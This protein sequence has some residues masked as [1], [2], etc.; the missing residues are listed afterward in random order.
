[1]ILHNLG[2]GTMA[3]MK[4]RIV[5]Y[6]YVLRQE[7]EKGILPHLPPHEAGLY[8]DEP[9]MSP[10]IPLLAVCVSSAGAD[11]DME[12]IR[13]A[14]QIGQPCGVIV[15]TEI[16]DKWRWL[17]ELH[18]I[19]EFRFVVAVGGPREVKKWFPGT[20]IIS[21]LFEIMIPGKQ[22]ARFIWEAV[23]LEI[24]RRAQDVGPIPRPYASP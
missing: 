8:G 24:S 18:Q 21:D 17:H 1:M 12:T 15:K 16:R 6:D 5:A 3:E 7:V 19:Q 14:Q 9:M 11:T 23:Q 20:R 10:R 22:I 2:R 4:L 13:R